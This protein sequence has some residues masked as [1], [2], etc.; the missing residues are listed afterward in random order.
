MPVALFFSFCFLLLH[1]VYLLAL[2]STVYGEYRRIYYC[3]VIFVSDCKQG[4]FCRTNT[5]TKG[6][7]ITGHHHNVTYWLHDWHNEKNLTANIIRSIQVNMTEWVDNFICSLRPA[8]PRH[9]A[10]PVDDNTVGYI[11]VSVNL[12]SCLSPSVCPVRHILEVTRQQQHRLNQHKYQRFGPI[13]DILHLTRCDP[14][15]SFFLFFYFLFLELQCTWII[16]YITYCD[17]LERN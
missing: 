6:E 7:T 10:R 16:M 5:K 13:S 2:H 1:L 15:S 3:V 14:V 4:R 11:L 8:T 12:L 9:W 17:C